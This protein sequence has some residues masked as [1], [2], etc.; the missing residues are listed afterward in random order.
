MSWNRSRL[1]EAFVSERSFEKKNVSM[2]TSLIYL[3]FPLSITAER[4]TF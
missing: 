3:Q 2:V 4:I 1:C